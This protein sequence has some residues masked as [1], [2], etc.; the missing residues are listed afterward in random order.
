M[1]DAERV[2]ERKLAR[3]Q[4]QEWGLHG[5]YNGMFKIIG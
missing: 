3:L 5:E 1:L 4:M 2:A